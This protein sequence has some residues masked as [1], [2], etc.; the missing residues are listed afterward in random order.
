MLNVGDDIKVAKGYPRV[1]PN[2][3]VTLLPSGTPPALL[4]R[5]TPPAL[6]PRG[7]PPDIPLDPVAGVVMVEVFIVAFGVAIAKGVLRL[8]RVSLGI[9]STVG[10]KMLKPRV[11]WCLNSPDHVTNPQGSRPSPLG[12]AACTYIDDGKFIVNCIYCIKI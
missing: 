5:G 12:I 4:P 1:L 2:L 9:Y 7:T 8:S 10:C 3:A 11:D 6:L